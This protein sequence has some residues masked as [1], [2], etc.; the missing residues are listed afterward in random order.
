MDGEKKEKIIMLVEDDWPLVEGIKIKLEK[1]GFSVVVAK[2]VNQALGYLED[3]AALDVIWLDHTL[4]GKE[5]GLDFLTQL[6]A[7]ERW[8][9]IPV[10]VVSNTANFDDVRSYVRLGAD[11]YY[12]KS[13]NRLN[14]VIEDI[15]SFL[16]NP[17]E[18][19]ESGPKKR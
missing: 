1:N 9:R 12:T 17:Q 16:E 2:T 3:L 6:K 13:D 10:F 18:P 11:Q 8:R 4:L 7:D 14:D 5:T 19:T 15:K